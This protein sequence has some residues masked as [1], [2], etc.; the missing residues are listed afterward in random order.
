MER[1]KQLVEKKEWEAPNIEKF[2]GCYP[3]GSSGE[4]QS[5]YLSKYIKKVSWYD[6]T[7]QDVQQ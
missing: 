4:E 5:T 6:I 2:R 7:L 1:S 3:L